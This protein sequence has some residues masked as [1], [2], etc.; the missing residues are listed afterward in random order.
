MDNINRIQIRS[1]QL[2]DSNW[3]FHKGDLKGAEKLEFDASEWRML[4]LP[5]DFSI[6]AP[7]DKNHP[8]GQSSGFLPGGIGW[9]RKEMDPLEIDLNHKL[10]IEFDGIFHYS[11]VW[12]NGHHLGKQ[13]Y[14]FTSFQY[15]LTPYL[16]PNA[17]NILAVRVD[18]NE[19]PTTRWYS[20]SGIYRHVW[21][22]KTDKLHIS[23]WGTY[24]TTP[25]I[26]KASALVNIK[27]KITN[28]YSDP[29]DCVLIS[30]ITDPEGEIVS[31]LKSEINLAAEQETEVKQELSITEPKL[32]SVDPPQLYNV[33]SEVHLEDKLVDDYVTPF[34]IR[35]IEL[36]QDQGLFI[37]DQPVKLK[38]V[39]LHHDAGCVGVAVPDR[40]LERRLEILKTM[41]CNAIRCSH[42]PPAPEL[43]T[44]CDQMGFLVIDEA[45]DKWDEWGYYKNLFKDWWKKDLGAMLYRDRNHPSIIMWS[46]GNE[47]INQGS[48]EMIANL[49]MLVEYV[50]IVDPTRPV[51][52]GLQ[53]I[54]RSIPKELSD[55]ERFDRMMA[56][57]V[58]IA[59]ITDVMS[60]NYQEQWFEIYREAYPEVIVIG[61]EIYGY[62]RGKGTSFNAYEPV[63][64]WFAVEDHDY[65]IGS[66][67]W[68]GFDYLGEAEAWPSKG[69]AASPIDSCG[70]RKPRSYFYQSVWSD[71]PMVQIAVFDDAMETN[72][73]KAH[74]EWP[75][76]ASHWNFPHFEQGHARLVTFT[77]CE[78]V[79]LF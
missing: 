57:M 66:F 36:D 25:K 8:G 10:F 72:P 3:L 56:N 7:Y 52:C 74:W 58:E 47:I 73:E 60:C 16:K 67:L 34:G 54:D 22:T 46:V 39:N 1:R 70:F 21:L 62:F 11:D 49:K 59:K 23:H 45:F 12:I 15:D 65:V 32:W 33:I 78:Q 9:Y 4:N 40:M 76:M 20:G 41:G 18:T 26:T 30:T 13:P 68:A 69:W 28:E 6:E 5:H 24:V 2:F 63:N 55:T 50:R 19:Q 48:P 53:P 64:P 79:E 43:L 29:I 37:N 71:E 35:K 51:T 77:N 42:N 31:K 14:G 38:G 75:K 27:T 17:K 44:L 61:S